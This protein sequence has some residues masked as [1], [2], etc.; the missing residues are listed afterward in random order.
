MEA[1]II[2]RMQDIIG[3]IVS[4]IP[5][6]VIIYSMFWGEYSLYVVYCVRCYGTWCLLLL[7]VGEVL[8]AGFPLLQIRYIYIYIVISRSCWWGASF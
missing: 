5:A 7:L 1:D 6:C 8:V 2:L 3:V 4:S